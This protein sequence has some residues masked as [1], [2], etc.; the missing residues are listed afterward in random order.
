VRYR[1][2]RIRYLHGEDRHP[3]LP[4]RVK[5]HVLAA[6][7]TRHS[8]EIFGQLIQRDYRFAISFSFLDE[9]VPGIILYLKA[10]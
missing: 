7:V 8:Q 4:E 2:D 5:F 3:S 10:D 6:R 1:S 9:L